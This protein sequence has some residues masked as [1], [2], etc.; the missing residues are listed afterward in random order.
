M[1]CRLSNLEPPVH[2]LSPEDVVAVQKMALVD[3]RKLE[4]SM[5]RMSQT[6]PAGLM[7]RTGSSTGTLPKNDLLRNVKEKNRQ[8]QKARLPAAAPASCC[9]ASKLPPKR[10]VSFATH[11][12]CVMEHLTSTQSV[13]CCAVHVASASA[14]HM[15]H[16][17]RRRRLCPLS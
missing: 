9:A 6:A 8:V 5:A 15:Q 7:T 1:H 3:K 12:V 14:A 17:C 11:N 2:H 10:C 16:T 4:S 13:C